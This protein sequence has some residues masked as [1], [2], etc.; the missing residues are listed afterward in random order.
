MSCYSIQHPCLH[1]RIAE[2]SVAVYMWVHLASPS[3]LQFIIAYSMQK[4]RGNLIMWP[5]AL[6]AHVVM[7]PLNSS[8]VPVWDQ[9][10][11]LCYEN[12]TSTCRA[13]SNI[14]KLV[15]L[16]FVLPKQDY[17]IISKNSYTPPFPGKNSNL[18]P[19]NQFVHVKMKLLQYPYSINK[20]VGSF[21]VLS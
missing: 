11:I 5:M 1:A 20:R 4:W 19:L 13:T 7:P 6:V 17:C 9:S 16:L 21:W 10:C 2:T 18:H 15:T 14:S 3:T 8:H 12:G